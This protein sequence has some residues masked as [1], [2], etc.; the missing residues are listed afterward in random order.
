[1]FG[2]K[3]LCPRSH[4]SCREEP[5]IS[6]GSSGLHQAN[7]LYNSSYDCTSHWRM[8]CS[9]QDDFK[10]VFLISLVNELRVTV[11]AGQAGSD[12]GLRAQGILL[13]GHEKGH[14]ISFLSFSNHSSLQNYNEK[15]KVCLQLG[16]CW[17]GVQL[18]RT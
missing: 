11:G 12:P 9:S 16:V 1:M 18:C 13:C 3:H 8:F 4:G 5:G 2:M 10:S 6:P 15:V 7:F 17:G 14:C